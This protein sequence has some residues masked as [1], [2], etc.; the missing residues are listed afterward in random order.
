MILKG[1]FPYKSVRGTN[2]PENEPDMRFLKVTL[3]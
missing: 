1:T 3:Y 2:D